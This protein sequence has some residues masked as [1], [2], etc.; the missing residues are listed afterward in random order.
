M[1][2]GWVSKS[3]IS[4]FHK[5]STNQLS[6]FRWSQRERLKEEKDKEAK[7]TEEKEALVSNPPPVQNNWAWL[8][9]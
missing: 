6:K 9:L 5:Q 2:S 3:K 4:Q 1:L 8:I 7:E